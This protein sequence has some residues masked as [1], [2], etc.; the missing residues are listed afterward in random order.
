M[1]KEKSI[2]AT[3]VFNILSATINGANFDDLCDAAYR[4]VH[5]AGYRKQE[6]ISVE[7]RLPDKY[8]DYICC[9]RNGT[10][11]QLTYNPKYKLFNVSHDNVE[12]A[13]DVTYW[14]PL[15]QAPKMKGG[16]E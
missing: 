11:W 12:N 2:E 5:I 8:G 14:M 1:S 10:I 16:D 3:E 13:M 9:T 7:E 4:I 15:P 6:W